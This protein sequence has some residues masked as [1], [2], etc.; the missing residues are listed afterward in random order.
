MISERPIGAGEIP[1]SQEILRKTTHMGALIVPGVYWWLG[2]SKALMLGIMIPSTCL[3]VAIDVAR[4]RNLGFWRNFACKIGGRMVRSHESAGDFTG[5]TYIL[6]SACC[7]IA[8]FDKPVAVAA[9]AFIIVGDTLAALI[10]RKFGRHKFGHK[11]V[12]G[13]LACLVGTV[14]VALLVPQLSLTVGLSGAVVATVV[15]A[16][17]TKIDDNISVP[18]L[19]GLAMT[20]LI[21]ILSTP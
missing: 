12:E 10:G 13:S 14:A 15:E 1:F 9:L 6:L 7:V 16:L 18:V 3:M 8:M 20:L 2:L 19:S 11:S 4:L 17:S 5:A 21:S